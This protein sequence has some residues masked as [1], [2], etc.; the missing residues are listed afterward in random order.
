MGNVPAPDAGR[1]R[2]EAV[3]LFLYKYKWFV[4]GYVTL[5]LIVSALTYKHYLPQATALLAQ[6]WPQ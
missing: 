4:V 3:R 6:Y 5:E 2:V 1:W